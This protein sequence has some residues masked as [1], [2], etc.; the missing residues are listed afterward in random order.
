MNIPRRLELPPR[1]AAAL[2]IAWVVVLVVGLVVFLVGC[3]VPDAAAARIAGVVPVPPAPSTVTM[4]APHPTAVTIPAIGATSTLIETGILPDGTAEV[5]PLE[6][7]EQA[8]WLRESPRPGDPGPAVLYG[9]IDG[10]GRRGVFADLAKLTV[11][12]QVL[13]DRQDAPRLVFVVYRVASVPKDGFPTAEVYG[14]VPGPE[15]R[16][17]S[18]GGPF[19]HTTGHYRD[20]EVVW[21]RLA[22]K[23]TP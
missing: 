5:P 12:D 9:H 21:A 19:D 17:I 23:G 7:P 11:G 6:H 8:S 16:L 20:N 15:L 22:P 10:H 4:L 13:I 3:G 1:V 18:C 2:A 14:D